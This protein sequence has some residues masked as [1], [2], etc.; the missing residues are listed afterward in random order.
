ML[1]SCICLS[2][3]IGTAPSPVIPQSLSSD[4]V[5]RN[6]H[7]KMQSIGPAMS[8][9]RVELSI[10]T[11]LLLLHG[12]SHSLKTFLFLTKRNSLQT[13]RSK[14]TRLLHI[15]TSS[16]IGFDGFIKIP[17]RPLNFV[18]AKAG[19]TIHLGQITCRILEDGS[20]TG[21]LSTIPCSKRGRNTQV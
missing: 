1:N 12:I 20:R 17:D 8:S 13:T 21:T 19:E 15:M 11:S 14:A 16:G 7:D 5:G 9:E 4:D 18:P 2:E 3:C 10:H 6:R